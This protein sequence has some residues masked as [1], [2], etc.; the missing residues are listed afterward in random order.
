MRDS[1]HRRL[2][3]MRGCLTALCLA[4][5]AI[6]ASAQQAPFTVQTEVVR[7]SAAKHTATNAADNS[8]VVVWLAPIHEA[9]DP[10]APGIAKS[11][12]KQPPQLVQHNKT[13]EPHVLVVEVG[14]LVQFPNKDPFFHNVF[15]LFD[16]KRFDL[17]LYEGGSSSTARFERPGVS[18]LFCNIHPEMSAIVVAVQT[19][20]FG[21]SDRAGHVIIGNVPDGRYSLHVWYER[22]NSEDLKALDRVIDIPESAHSLEPLKVTDTG[23]FN[24][25][26]KN[27]YGQDYPPA[28][29]PAYKQP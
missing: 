27:K 20:Y 13:F 18:F 17:G 23:D 5:T 12:A 28:A 6:S 8:N 15:S 16:G 25:T 21:V 2:L 24:V 10:V 14:S 26:H 9:G 22:S 1:G 7:R 11:Q 29:N 3:R 19:P 4:A